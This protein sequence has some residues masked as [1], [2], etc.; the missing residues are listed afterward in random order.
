MA[1]TV[2]NSCRLFLILVVVV[3]VSAF[4]S[5]ARADVI[6]YYTGAPYTS[7]TQSG[8]GANLTGWV[9]LSGSSIP[10]GFTGSADWDGTAGPAEIPIVNFFLKSGTSS[11]SSAS[12]M[13]FPLGL[14]TFENG[15][16]KSWSLNITVV[17]P[18]GTNFVTSQIFSA[19][20]TGD[21]ASWYNW[22]PYWDPSNGPNPFP[23]QSLVIYS[24]SNVVSGQWST[25]PPAVPEP[26][27]GFIFLFGLLGLA[28]Y[29]SAGKKLRP[30]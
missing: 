21:S 14:I 7:G 10:A 29:L 30:F 20:S 23:S 18:Y 6:L 26:A 2:R 25:D 4:S 27:S 28:I 5:P 16:I 8:L 15:A 19:T 17:Q 12:T 3:V 11:A 13:A 22:P 9:D 1:M 24:A